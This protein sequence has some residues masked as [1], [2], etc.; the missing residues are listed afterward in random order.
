[1]SECK[2]LWL[3]GRSHAF[4]KF[5][6]KFDS[7][8]KTARAQQHQATLA[9]RAY[10]GYAVTLPRTHIGVGPRGDAEMTAASV[11]AVAAKHLCQLTL[12]DYHGDHGAASTN[13]CVCVAES[14]RDPKRNP[15]RINVFIQLCYDTSV[16]GKFC[17]RPQAGPLPCC[18]V[19]AQFN[20]SLCAY[21]AISPQKSALN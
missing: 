9:K 15:Q 7:S 8:D 19:A 4:L 14:T 11:A 12:D 5:K 16:R 10:R 3:R 18:A 13:K 2:Q 1:M 21:K 6:P 17:R 20:F